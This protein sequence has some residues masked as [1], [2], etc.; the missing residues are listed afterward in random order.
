VVSVRYAVLVS[1]RN[2]SKDQVALLGD[3][4]ADS[5]RKRAKEM[6]LVVLE[7]E[8]WIVLI[9]P[10][11]ACPQ[12]QAKFALFEASGKKFPLRVR[13]GDLPKAERQSVESSL[14]QILQFL[15]KAM[16]LDDVVLGSKV[17]AR[18]SF[19][20][21]SDSK[22]VDL[23]RDLASEIRKPSDLP[24]VTVPPG[25]KLANET[26]NPLEEPEQAISFS[27]NR[28]VT[29]AVLNRAV[30]EAG[31]MYNDW[32]DKRWGKVENEFRDRLDEY[33]ASDPVLAAIGIKGALD[34]DSLGPTA[35]KEIF[36]QLRQTW[37]SQQLDPSE[38]ET[39]LQSLSFL[40]ARSYL[41]L[42]FKASATPCDTFVGMSI[43]ASPLGPP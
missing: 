29:R 19:S 17:Q 33:F 14:G 30:R 27:V 15:P 34:W 11:A 24:V 25:L 42:E 37:K 18:I 39:R 40:G 13:L 5:I 2:P 22:K 9:A 38:I 35:Q 23:T 12:S 3:N 41:M 43:Y 7:N 10:S 31:Q 6:G 32:F 26:R 4:K 8:K 16:N 28:S 1:G 20:G 36:E 21:R